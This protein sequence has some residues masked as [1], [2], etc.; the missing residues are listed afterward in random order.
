MN[1]IREQI[2]QEKNY[3]NKKMRK[4]I[5]ITIIILIIAM[6][7]LSIAMVV[8]KSKKLTISFNGQN[9]ANLKSIL[10]FEEDGKL[11]IPIRDISSIFNYKSYNGDYV[12]KSEEID[13][14]YVE[15]TEEVAVFETGSN[16]IQKINISTKE[17]TY[18]TIDEPVQ[19]IDGKL[20]TTPNGI[21]IAYNSNFVYNKDT[22]KIS[23]TTMEYLIQ[24]YTPSILQLGFKELS[25]KFEDE[26]AILENMTIVKNEKGKYGVYDIAKKQEILEVKYDEI[27]YIPTSKEFLVNNNSKIGILTSEGKERIKVQYDEIKLISQDKKLYVVKKDEK[28]GVID[29]NEETVITINCSK[30]GIEL[31]NFKKNNIKSQY[32]LFDR[33]IPVMKKDYWELYDIETNSYINRKYNEQ[34]DLE[35]Y[36]VY[37]SLGCISSGKRNTENVLV[38][39][40][41][42][43]IIGYRNK[44]YFLINKYG[45]ELLNEAEFDQ[46]YMTEEDEEIQY[47]LVQGEKT[48]DALKI[49]ERLKQKQSSISN[50]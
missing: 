48:F 14:C 49:L 43:I 5:L 50:E 9:Y 35:S 29:Q 47:W 15:T 26:K 30:I 10:K 2:D 41:Y 38:I 21:S 25:T 40:E 31:N 45:E 8:V 39:P 1:L 36:H 23:I 22:N 12:N 27:K 11:Y 33:I 18:Y 19:M 32:L 13:K 28:Y 37:N 6:I 44:K 7:A 46:I 16:I 24:K 3:K 34:G 20:Y 4:I 17:E 42:E